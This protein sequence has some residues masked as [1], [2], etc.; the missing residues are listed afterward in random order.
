MRARECEVFALKTGSTWIVR[1]R[2][3][4]ANGAT[5]GGIE[6]GHYANADA[7]RAAM[8]AAFLSIKGTLKDYTDGNILVTLAEIE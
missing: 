5:V 6:V 8:R 3:A 1:A 4:D 2:F 7:T